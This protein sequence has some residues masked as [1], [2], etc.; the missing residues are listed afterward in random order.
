[1]RTRRLSN[2]RRRIAMGAALALAGV[3]LAACGGGDDGTVINLYGGANLPGFDKVIERCND[4]ADG[5]YRIVGNLLPADADGQREQLVRR[6][7]A[8]D[9]GMDLLGLD[10]TWT[11][12]FAEAGWIVELDEQ[13][14]AEATKDTLKATL[15]TARWQDRLYG[16]PF[17][18]NVQLLWYRESLSPEPP[19]TWDE[20]LDIAG[21]LRDE[22]KPHTIGL[23]ASRYE[24]YVVVFNTILSSFGGS[25][26]NEDGTKAVVDEHTVEALDLLSRFAKSGLAMRA[27]SNAQE[28][29]VYAEM[30]QGRA[31]FILNWPY[32]YSTMRG[33]AEDNPQIAEVFKDLRFAPLPATVEGEPAR[34]TL[35]GRNFAISAYSEHPE[36]TYD[37]AMCLRDREGQL[38]LALASGEPPVLRSV[39][40]DPEFQEAYPMHAE[41]LAQLQ[42]AVP[43]PQ[44]PLYQNV[45]TIISDTLSP[46]S[47]IDPEQTA[48]DLREEIQRALEGRGILP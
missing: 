40:D 42:V 16:I 21:R 26:V 18:T 41:L 9:S 17:H 35:G 19:A 22:G 32:V 34:G 2:T 30:Q 20:M 4:K 39:F 44:T 36:E 3:T 24:G 46:P 33:E 31:A 5:A 11:A 8:R 48:D 45:S 12:E 1:M 7:A 29:E 23:T 6:L 43:R 10:V 38:Q 37:A 47:S 14:A 15:E 27:V 25:L 28:P 13:Q